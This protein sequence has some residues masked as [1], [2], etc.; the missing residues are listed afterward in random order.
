ML[1]L[2][3][4]MALWLVAVAILFWHRDPRLRRRSR[5]PRLRQGRREVRAQHLC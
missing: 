2:T 3:R 5:C 1:G 4:T